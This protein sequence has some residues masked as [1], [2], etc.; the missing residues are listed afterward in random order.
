M[1]QRRGPDADSIEPL[2]QKLMAWRLFKSDIDKVIDPG[3]AGMMRSLE[4][5]GPGR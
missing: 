1:L 5:N 4:L 2:L 3:M